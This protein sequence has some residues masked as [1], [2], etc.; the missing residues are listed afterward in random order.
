MGIFPAYW[1]S[2]EVSNTIINSVY[3]VHYI[4]DSIMNITHFVKSTK[5]TKKKQWCNDGNSVYPMQE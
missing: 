5:K 3:I 2:T 1:E 4:V